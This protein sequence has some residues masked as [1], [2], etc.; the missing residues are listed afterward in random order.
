MDKDVV[1]LESRNWKLDFVDRTCLRESER[2]E[3]EDIKG[4]SLCVG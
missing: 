3:E 1:K 4:L 2:E